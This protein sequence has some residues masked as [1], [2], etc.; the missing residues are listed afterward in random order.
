VSSYDHSISANNWSNGTY[1][2]SGWTPSGSPAPAL[3]TTNRRTSLYQSSFDT[4]V[5]VYNSNGSDY[6]SLRYTYLTTPN[7]WYVSFW[8]YRDYSTWLLDSDNSKFWRAYWDSAGSGGDMILSMVGS[9]ATQIYAHAEGTLDAACYPE[10]QPG[11][12]AVAATYMNAD[13]YSPQ[14]YDV[15]ADTANTG[16]SL[17]S[18]VH[19]ELYLVFNPT[20]GVHTGG[21]GVLLINGK[22]HS[23]TINVT[24]D[25]T[26]EVRDRLWPLFGGN[27][28]GGRSASG[29]DYLDQIYM[30]TTPAHVF[31][32]SRND[33]AWPDNANATHTE[34]QVPITWSATGITFTLNQGTFGSSDTVYLYVVDGSGNISNAKQITLAP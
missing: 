21:V 22:L 5:S 28:S 12:P 20:S 10:G 17:Q 3:S 2:A 15:R 18:W 8:Q 1:G 34:I 25:Y 19:Y 4:Q 30:D 29:Y 33:V 16:I 31:I 6:H 7:V 32:S 23:R 27:V 11:C 14:G 24:L 13:F 26:G 9:N